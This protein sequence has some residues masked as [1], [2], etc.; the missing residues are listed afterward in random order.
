MISLYLPPKKQLSDAMKLLNEEYGTAGSIKSAIMQKSV[1]TAIASV[2]ERLKLYYHKFPTNGLVIF[3]GTIYGSDGKSEKILIDFEPFRP[4]NKYLY[5]CNST[6]LLD[7]LKELLVQDDTYGFIVVDGNGGLFGRV[8]GGHKETVHKLQVMLPKK[9]GRGGQSQKRFERI[10]DEKRHHYLRA[11]GELCTKIFISNDRPNVKGLIVAGSAYIKT[12]LVESDMFDQRLKP[13]VLKV[14]DVSYG[15]ENGF[16]Q[17]IELS[18][19]C[20]KNVK[21]VNEKNILS[22][23]FSHLCKDTGM[24]T[25]GLKETVEALVENSTVKHLLVSEGLDALRV[26][27]RNKKT[28]KEIVKFLRKEELGEEKM[29]LDK[30]SGEDLEVIQTE[31]LVDWISEHYQQYATRLTFITN[32][33]SEGFQF[34]KGF[35]GIGGFLHYKAAQDYGDGELYVESDDDEFL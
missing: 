15:G 23:F 30:D 31:E 28:D 20:L 14:V 10:T 19:E 11:L 35:S 6:F 13:I 34:L 18:Q 4:I 2:R 22:D 29:F 9:H 16:S 12:K 33:S 3:C 26:V 5:H 27:L 21:Y 7:P 32:E 25:Y 1:M 17:A 8:T 24:V